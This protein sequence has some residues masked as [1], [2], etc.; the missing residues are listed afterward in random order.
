MSYAESVGYTL[1]RVWN[2][3]HEKLGT[4]EGE[5]LIT[6]EWERMRENIEK[7]RLECEGRI[8]LNEVKI[9]YMAGRKVEGTSVYNYNW[10]KCRLTIE[11]WWTATD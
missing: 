9:I 6:P 1:P 7:L 5:E 2:E 3:V 10:W 4:A 11:V 8:A